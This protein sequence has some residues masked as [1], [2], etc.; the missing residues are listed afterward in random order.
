MIRIVV[1][2]LEKNVISFQNSVAYLRK[3]I[4]KYL[5]FLLEDLQFIL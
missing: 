3:L 5:Q 4:F 2:N 1:F